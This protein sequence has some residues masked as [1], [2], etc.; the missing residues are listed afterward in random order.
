MPKVINYKLYCK[1]ECKFQLYKRMADVS[2]FYYTAV[3]CIKLKYNYD[4][5]LLK[6]AINF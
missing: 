6:F 5:S 1:K 4:L 2:F 3:D